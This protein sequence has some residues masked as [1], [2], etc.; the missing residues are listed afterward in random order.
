M[1]ETVRFLAVSIILLVVPIVVV[2]YV[3]MRA[4]R[5]ANARDQA[6][7]KARKAERLAEA[8][9]GVWLGERR[10]LKAC[11]NCDVFGITLPF[12]D[13]QGRTFCSAFCRDYLAARQP[14]FCKRCVSETLDQHVDTH[15][16]ELGIGWSFGRPRQECGTCRSAIRTLWLRALLIPILPMGSFRTIK[17]SPYR[18]ASR[19]IRP[20]Y[21][22]HQPSRHKTDV[23][24]RGGSARA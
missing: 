10:F 3:V 1:P 20:G 17:T 8:D 23:E 18:F 7:R 12:Q 24:A 19:K 16:N 14:S 22:R 15:L 4:F 5:W 9:Q 11:S 21:R 6:R 13:A 2:S